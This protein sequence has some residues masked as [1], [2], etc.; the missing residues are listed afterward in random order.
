MVETLDTGI[1]ERKRLRLR[2]E[3]LAEELDELESS[4]ADTCG[5]FHHVIIALCEMGH[6]ELAP[7]VN[8]ALNDFR[9]AF[10]GNRFDSSQAH[11]ALVTF[12]TALMTGMI[13]GNGGGSG[14]PGANAGDAGKHVALA[15]LANLYMNDVSFD[16]RVDN[17]IKEVHL[18]IENNQVHPAMVMVA[19]LIE[20]YREIHD[21]RRRQAEQAMKEVLFELMRTEEDLSEALSVTTDQ[22]SRQGN[23]YE[24]HVTASMGKLAKKMSGTTD[25]ESLKVSVLE[26]I[27]YLRA[28]IRS[29]R[30]SEQRL[31]N[32]T[33]Q[34]LDK[35]KGALDSTRQHLQTIEKQSERLSR[36]AFTD[37]LTKVWNKRAL[38]QQMKEVLA[39]KQLWPLSLIVLD[40]DHFKSINDNFGH[41]AGDLALRTISEQAQAALRRKSDTLF[42][43]AGDEFVVILLNTGSS[44]AFEIGERIRNAA[45]NI[46]FTYKG[47]H[48]TRI[49]L[50]LGI[51]EAIEQD[52]PAK[53]FGRAD[54]ALLEAKQ[55]G[56]NQCR[57]C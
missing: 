1:K 10:N 15:L 43:Y 32:K 39:Q 27:R 36:E 53:L 30:A 38:S 9:L 33:Q 44:D 16:S 28:E 26:H 31:L 23:E 48:E 14:A 5:V 40:I 52:T 54:A 42:R 8:E 20:S 4:Y 57:I 35:L 37:P 13:K 56:R 6:F 19:D 41:Q 21:R 17:V 47:M 7:E 34:E 45:E 11:G 51:S 50:S 18:H 29:K 46:R 24:A 49:S 55:A 12:R 25:V 22:L 3:K 2:L